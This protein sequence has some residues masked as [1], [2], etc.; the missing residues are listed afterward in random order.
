MILTAVFQLITC[1]AIPISFTKFRI[2]KNDITRRFKVSFGKSISLLIFI[3]LSF[4]LTQANILA[5]IIA[6]FAHII[7]FA[8][9]AFSF[10]RHDFVKITAAFKSTWSMF[11]YLFFITI[12]GYFHHIGILLQPLFLTLFFITISILFILLVQQ[13]KAKIKT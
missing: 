4:L 9:Y 8:I 5:L 7:L 13:K 10:Y 3:L 12:F 2:S 1:L 6:L 11:V